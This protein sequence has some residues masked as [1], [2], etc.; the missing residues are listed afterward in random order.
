M[1]WRVFH[2]GN[3]AF[4]LELRGRLFDLGAHPCCISKKGLGGVLGGPYLPS[5]ALATLARLQRFG[6]PTNGLQDAHQG[7][8]LG[9]CWQRFQSVGCLRHNWQKGL[10]G[11]SAWCNSSWC[12]AWHR[13]PYFVPSLQMARQRSTILTLWMTSSSE[14]WGNQITAKDSSGP[15]TAS[16]RGSKK[17]PLVSDSR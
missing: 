5:C 4:G 2:R 10:C 13:M 8:A 6:L 7:R 9:T 11:Q 15:G 17:K 1:C 14:L 12:L 16:P 3:H